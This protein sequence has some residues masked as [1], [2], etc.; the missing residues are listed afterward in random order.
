MQDQTLI[1]RAM[2]L[3]FAVFASGQM[4]TAQSVIETKV[5]IQAQ[6][7]ESSKD[8]WMTI[9]QEGIRLSHAGRYAEAE[10]RFRKALLEAEAFDQSDYRLWASLSNVAYVT[11]EQGDLSGSEKLYRRGLV[12]R[13][14]RHGGATKKEAA[15]PTNT[16]GHIVQ[17]DR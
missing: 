3:V 11:G 16:H 2:F 9:T 13:R 1:R 7:G 8:L 14:K 4:G 10:T 12:L 15:P 6:P 5:S 17:P